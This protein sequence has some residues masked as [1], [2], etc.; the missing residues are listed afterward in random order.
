MVSDIIFESIIRFINAIPTLDERHFRTLLGVVFVYLMLTAFLIVLARFKRIRFLS[1]FLALIPASFIFLICVFFPNVKLLYAHPSGDPKAPVE[2]Y[3]T[4]LSEGRLSDGYDLLYGTDTEGTEEEVGENADAAVYYSLLSG[5]FSYEYNGEVQL[6]G[7]GARVPVRVGYADLDSLRDDLKNETV[8]ELNLMVQ[9]HSRKEI[10]GSDDSYEDWALDQAYE[11]A[12]KKVT[13]GEPLSASADVTVNLEFD[14]GSWKIVPSGE[15]LELM[16]GGILGEPDTE[17]DL[18]ENI[19]LY[20]ENV[21]KETISE[22]PYIPKLYSIPE[23]QTFGFLPDQEKYHVLEDP[24]D[25]EGVLA[26]NAYLI[27]DE[28]V[29]FD[30]DAT[31]AKRQK[32]Q[33]YS[34]ESI[35]VIVWKEACNN[36]YCTFAEVFVSDGSQIRRKITQDTF[37]SSSLKGASELAT[38]AQA[39][40]AMNGDYYK[41][42]NMGICVYDRTVS[43][44]TTQLDTCFFNSN[45]DMIL[46]PA[47]ELKTKE[48]AQQFVDDNDIVFSA[49]FG[50]ILVNNGVPKANLN[51]RIGETMHTYSRSAIGQMGERHYLCLAIG[52][53]YPST[54]GCYIEDEQQVMILKGC[55]NA[56]ALDGGQTAEIVWKNKMYNLVDFGEE[57]MVSDI[58]YFATAVPEDEQ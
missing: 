8:S 3:L 1:A 23:G 32:V 40:V 41:Y 53:L 12:L 11:E 19:S 27:G 16:G 45:G 51:Y 24:H 36:C 33:Y 56:Y 49:A 22:L 46:S 54:L 47:G 9:S 25:I 39:V 34:D 20:A 7:M 35:F 38:E 17:K 42:R 29:V 43:R 31:F 4:A 18:R 58:I 44:F 50:P 2:A 26:E 57:R 14:G 10:Y 37:G 28:R 48:E 52:C 5:G 6:Q 55:D 13:A 21:K 15:L 30:P